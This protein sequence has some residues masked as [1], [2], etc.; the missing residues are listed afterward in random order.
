MKTEKSSNMHGK[1]I[2]AKKPAGTQPS[3]EPMKTGTHAKHRPN[4]K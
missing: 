1:P 2:A 4:A 3:K